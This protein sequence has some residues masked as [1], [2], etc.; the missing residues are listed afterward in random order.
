MFLSHTFVDSKPNAIYEAEDT[1]IAET[2]DER[3]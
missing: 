2:S 3:K 1:W